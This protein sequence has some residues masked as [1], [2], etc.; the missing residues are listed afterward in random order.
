MYVDARL[1]CIYALLC[2]TLYMY[3]VKSI[4][5]RFNNFYVKNLKMGY[6][7]IVNKND[8]E[9]ILCKYINVRNAEA[10]LVK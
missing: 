2:I 10:S 3:K 1:M 5:I 4:Y 8:K 9:E 7:I 6:N